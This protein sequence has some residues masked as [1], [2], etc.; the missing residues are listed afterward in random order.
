MV[1]VNAFSAHL[2]RF[3]S[4][5]GYYYMWGQRRPPLNI[6]QNIL[7]HVYKLMDDL[8]ESIKVK[9]WKL[10]IQ[11]FIVRI[12]LCLLKPHENVVVINVGV[13]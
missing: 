3:E 9:L 10:R 1:K 11:Y 12:A 2:H 5:M 8:D 6:F 4:G 7:T 13:N